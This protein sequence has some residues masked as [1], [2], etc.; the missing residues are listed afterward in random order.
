M[1]ENLAII[2]LNINANSKFHLNSSVIQNLRKNLLSLWGK[3]LW[4]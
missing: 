3:E 1:N 4:I 2:V